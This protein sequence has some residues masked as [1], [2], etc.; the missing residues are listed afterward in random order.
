ML[1]EHLGVKPEQVAAVTRDGSLF[2]ALDQLHSRKRRLLP[3]ADGELAEGEGVPQIEAVADPRRPIAPETLLADFDADEAPAGGGGMAL[4]LRIGLVLAP[5]VI[6][7]VAWRYTPLSEFMNPQAFSESL[8]AGGS[9]GPLLAVGLF[10]LLGLVAFPVNVLIVATAAAF[11]LWPGLLYAAGGAM[12]SAVLTYL[13]GRRMGPGLL[14]KIIGPR[15]N[16]VSRSIAKNGILAVTMVRLMPI[17][18]FTLVN[19]VAGAIRIPLLDYTI[20]TALGLAPGL[21]LMTAL[22]DRLLKIVTEPSLTDILGFVVVLICWGAL[23]YGLQSLI[24]WIRRMMDRKKD[25]A[26]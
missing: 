3:I 2:R 25:A 17:A 26:A 23:S 22:G 8:E 15:I 7:G 14:R 4:W 20:G 9:L 21:L 11:G 19:L 12:V 1:A 24:K 5:I 6:L 18:P 16:R 13:V 10:M